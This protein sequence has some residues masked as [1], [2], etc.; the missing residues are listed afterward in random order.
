MS[1]R[2]ENAPDHVVRLDVCQAERPDAGSIYHP[3]LPIER[4]RHRLG[5]GVLALAD[6][7]HFARG[8]VRLRDKTIHQCGLA[9]AGM[10]EE[11]GDLVGEQGSDRVERIF[12]ARRDDG[13]V[14]IFELCGE[15]FGR[16]QI[17]FRQAQ[18]RGEPAGVRGDQSS[19]DES[20]ARRRVGQGHHDQQ[21]V[22][23]G[24]HH[25]FGRIGVIGGAAQH[26]SALTAAHDPGQRVR[27]TGQVADDVDVVA[28]PR[29]GCGPVRVPRIATTR[30]C[31]SRSRAQPHRP[32]STV[33]TIADWASAWPGRILVRGREPLPG[34]I[35]TSDSS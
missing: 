10:S 27:A 13:E 9:H 1:A 18:H 11:H 32:R 29:W 2:S 6:A 16:G 35:R 14:Q 34:L 26:C 31:G 15:R 5:G 25:P 30:W 28:P 17:G 20:G 4:E 3:A 7:G 19:F 12:S 23:V 33:T 8:S 24:D 22:G 21:L